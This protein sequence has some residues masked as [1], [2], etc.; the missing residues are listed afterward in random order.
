MSGCRL[1]AFHCRI[2]TRVVQRTACQRVYLDR[3]TQGVCDG[4]LPWCQSVRKTLGMDA[5]PRR[6]EHAVWPTETSHW[7]NLAAN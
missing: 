2:L 5:T 6:Q 1:R 3:R 4:E 7:R